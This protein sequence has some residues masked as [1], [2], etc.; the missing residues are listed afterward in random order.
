MKNYTLNS[1]DAKS[2]ILNYEIEN[3]KIIIKF[4]NNENYIIP[5]TEKNEKKILNRMKNQFLCLN[6]DYKLKLNN[7]F[8][9]RKVKIFGWGLLA[10]IIIILY[11]GKG[12]TNLSI[13]S[14]IADLTCMTYNIYKTIH[15][16]NLLKDL[17]KNK[18]LLD[19]QEK[20]NKMI[21]ENKNVLTNT[22]EKIKNMVN[23]TP[24][25]KPVFTL[26][27]I[28]IVRLGEL[29]SILE[30]IRKEEQFNFDDTSINETNDEPLTLKKTM[31]KMNRF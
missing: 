29:K 17:E 1:E 5:Y 15:L 23:S 24:E 13:T 12:Y 6:K 21:K 3:N 16:K 14:I 7:R 9:S 20:L 19:N 28:E 31:D 8:E 25:D 18:I 27:S 22:N 4:A 2:F 26:N 10:L 11:N 30:T